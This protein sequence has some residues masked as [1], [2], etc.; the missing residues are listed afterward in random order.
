VTFH[1]G[2]TVTEVEV[3]AGRAVA[4][5]TAAGDRI[6]ADV[7]VLNPDL[8]TAYRELLPPARAPRRLARLRYSPSCF[9]L[10]AGAG[11]HAHP[12]ADRLDAAHH[13]IHFGTAWRRTFREIIDRGELMS[14]PSF[15]V[16]VPSVTEPALAPVGGHAFHVLFPTPNATVGADLDWSVIGPRYRDEVVDVLERH[17]YDG[18]GTAI[19]VEST[20]T[21]ADWLA[22]GMT[23]GAPFAAAHTFGQ[24][25]PFRPNNLA[26][27]LENVVFVGS[28]TRPGV[29]VPM[30]LISGRLA[31]E[32]VVGPQRRGDPGQ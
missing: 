6:A 12:E 23:A 18:F 9:L 2:T 22:R 15:L 25:G 10:L 16:S 29:G 3:R 8:P 13:T 11:A 4:V 1:Y 32:R 24:T 31:A 14:D 17:G 20:T 27:G 28:G 26:P 21:P 5:R 30:V 19:S 7:V